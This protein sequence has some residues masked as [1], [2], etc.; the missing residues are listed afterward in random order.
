MA[1]RSAAPPSY[2]V[3]SMDTF[4]GVSRDRSGSEQKEN[5]FYDLTNWRNYEREALRKRLGGGKVFSQTEASGSKVRGLHTYRS[6]A[7]V[8]TYIKVCNQKI[9]KSTGGAWTEIT[10]GA[11]TWANADCWF[12]TLKT[13]TTGVSNTDSGTNELSTAVTIKDTDKTF[14]V[15]GFVG[16]ILGVG[17]ENKLITANDTQTIY[18]AERFDTNPSAAAYT[19]KTRQSE[20]FVANGTDFYKCDGTTFTRLDNSIF[21]YAFDGICS[22]AGRLFGWKGNRLHWSDFGSGQHFS[23]NAWRDFGSPVQRVA[24]LGSDMLIIYEEERVTVMFG[25]SADTFTFQDLLVGIGTDC[26]KSVATFHGLYQF[27]LDRKIGAC[28]LTANSIQRA[29]DSGE[30]LSV[31]DGYIQNLLLGQSE[32]NLNAACA[33]V[34]DD[35]YHLCVD[36][37]W[38]VLNVRASEQTNFNDWVW[39]FDNRP[40]AM[41]ANVLGHFGTK[42]VAGAQ[43]NGQVYEIEQAGTYTD[44]GT[45]IAGVIEKQDWNPGNARSVKK[46][47]ALA[48]T[49]GAAGA[50]VSESFFADADGSSYSSAIKTIDLNTVGDTELRIPITANSSTG[51]KNTGK[52]ISLKITESAT[53]L[54]PDI[55]QIELLY[56]PGV[57]R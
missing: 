48:V 29:G 37:D 40:D 56:Y 7:G 5:E 39:S 46:F 10:S 15:N 45:T 52:K 25:D 13:V 1:T 35:L 51:M 43:D 31:S 4:R 21:A 17:S 53:G 32:A 44:D 26:P 3:R 12:A 33:E 28:I 24:S 27:F 47:W 41:D 55:E 8:E 38:Y 14:T 11:P 20:F 42:F 23:R 50:T 6:D 16:Q 57:I 34:H 49:Q 36:D 19:V 18:I 54:V 22:H 9:F 30:P 2:S